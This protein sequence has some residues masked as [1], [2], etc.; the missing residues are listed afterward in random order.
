MRPREDGQLDGSP[1]EHSSGLSAF[2][3]PLRSPA[4][5]STQTAAGTP[6]LGGGNR[7]PADTVRAVFVCSVEGP[8]GPGGRL[9]EGAGPA[10]PLPRYRDQGVN[11]IIRFM[12][13]HRDGSDSNFRIRWIVSA[14]RE[15]NCSFRATP[16]EDGKGAILAIQER[17]L[18]CFA[19]Q[20]E[21]PGRC[22]RVARGLNY[23]DYHRDPGGFGC[24]ASLSDCWLWPRLSGSNRNLCPILPRDGARRDSY[25]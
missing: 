20:L 21:L 14:A 18:S 11:Q 1:R 22:S 4:P 13:R 24:A 8:A 3:Q 15:F 16:V 10:A 7:D 25:F 2:E 17:E 9:P 19:A 5:S 12:S 23:P 6:T